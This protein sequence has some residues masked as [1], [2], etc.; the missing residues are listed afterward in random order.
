MP[1]RLPLQQL[2]QGRT[3]NFAHRGA[4]H[5]APE[6][7]L[8]AYELAAQ[9]GADGIEL[10]VVLTADDM[11]VCIHDELLDKTT[12]GHGPVRALSL[13]AIKELD[14]GGHFGP[15]FA[16]ERMPTL[17]EVFE[18]VGK[19][20]LVNVELKGM[21]RQPD[22]MEAIVNDCIARHNMGERVIISAFNPLRLR[23]MNRINPRLPLGFLHNPLTLFRGWDGL[24]RRFAPHVAD[25]PHH[26]LVTAGYMAWARRSHLRVNVW[27]VNEPARMQVLRDLGVDMI[28]TDRPDIL[29]AVLHGER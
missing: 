18:A 25:H 7:T 6:N 26:E 28:I 10:D 5:D 23:R 12:D 13:A 1:S 16:G 14:A 29:R 4:R 9:L 27:T 24:L 22:G 2:Y 21:S 11:P 19:R 20:L 3:L 15:Q 8:A 17:D